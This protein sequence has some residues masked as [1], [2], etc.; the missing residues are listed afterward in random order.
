MNNNL[1]LFG[2]HFDNQGANQDQSYSQS[3]EDK[4]MMN[5]CYEPHVHQMAVLGD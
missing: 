3:K 1:W 2:L 4:N 5:W